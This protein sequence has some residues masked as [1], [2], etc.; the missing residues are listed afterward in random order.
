MNFIFTKQPHTGK[1]DV[2]YS[3]IYIGE[4][5]VVMKERN[6]VDWDKYRADKTLRM[7]VGERY[8]MSYIPSIKISGTV[9]RVLGTFQNKEDAANAMLE[10]H[11]NYHHAR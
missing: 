9:S 10:S 2:W 1:I 8:N 4:I 11:R 5:F 7:T 6:D 3:K